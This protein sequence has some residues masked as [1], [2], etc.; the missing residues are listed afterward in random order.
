MKRQATKPTAQKS[1]EPS[2]EAQENSQALE[3]TQESSQATAQKVDSSAD[4]SA[5]A[6][7]RHAAHAA[8]DD[9]EVGAARDDDEK[10][11][12]SE[13]E[14][15]TATPSTPQ[16]SSTAP[17]T[18]TETPK[19]SL[20]SKIA[21][22]ES[23]ALQS[24]Q[25]DKTSGL[26]TKR[27]EATPDSTPQAESLQTPQPP[28]LPEAPDLGDDDPLAPELDQTDEKKLEAFKQEVA[29]A[30]K[31][32]AGVIESTHYTL[33]GIAELLNISSDLFRF[34]KY[35]AQS[36]SLSSK[37]WAELNA[38][39][40]AITSYINQ[41]LQSL[42]TQHT[43]SLAIYKLVETMLDE[44]KSLSDSTKLD[45]EQVKEA[46]QALNEL[47]HKLAKLIS[48]SAELEA[49]IKLAEALKQ[50][51]TNLSQTLLNEMRTELLRDKEGYERELESKKDEYIALLDTKLGDLTKKL[52]E[53]EST[54]T[55]KS[56]ELAEKI[57]EI[58]SSVQDKA[59]ETKQALETKGQAIKGEL[60][61]Y[62]DEL[63]AELQEIIQNAG[64]DI[65]GSGSQEAL[66]AIKRAKDQALQALQEKKSELET[67]LAELG[68]QTKT[69]LEAKKA[70]ALESINTDKTTAL[71]TITQEKTR[72]LQEINALLQGLKPSSQS[73]N[74]ADSELGTNLL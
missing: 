26:S 31:N 62:K 48:L 9:R 28:L 21:E 55:Q 66:N 14:S 43:Q 4:S 52:A 18:Q 1:Q 46:L 8:R 69:E 59:Q 40:Q 32:N 12:S 56:Q 51:V 39:L 36:I 24:E 41:A 50:E 49:Q 54:L 3:S 20:D 37:Q 53:F 63:K 25:G 74:L 58:E 57:A 27:D 2:Q 13:Q 71:E 70:I 19:E 29:E 45:L 64:G 15:A 11:D 30:I 67:Q 44:A 65:S 61:T 38:N 68:N 5:A 23:G 33:Q 17:S 47:D 72:T 42:A 60:E 73:Q 16:D 10:V 22:G 34:Y 7:N 6:M 35:H